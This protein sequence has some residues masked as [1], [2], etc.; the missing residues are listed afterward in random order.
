VRTLWSRER[1]IGDRSF[2]GTVKRVGRIAALAGVILPLVLIGILKFTALEIDGLKPALLLV[3]SPWSARAAVAGG[4]LGAL[5]L[6]LTT[7]ILFA[8]PIW[9]TASGGSPWLND[10]GTFLFKDVA[11]LGIS[12]FVLGDGLV[13][14]S[15]RSAA[16]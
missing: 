12:L 4:A 5:T 10:T 2:G 11:L 8:V 9:E 6:L 3:M 16:P 13:R 15:S 14:V 1:N 7:S